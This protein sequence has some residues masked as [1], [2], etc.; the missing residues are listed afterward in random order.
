MPT[1]NV[2][3]LWHDL[4]CGGYREDLPAWRALAAATGGPV[5]DVGAGT[6]RVT[7]DLAAEGFDVVALDRDAALLA[8]LEHR[9]RGLAVET[10]HADAHEFEL[11]RR[12][13][14][15]LVPMQTLQLLDG[16]AG[17]E[18][19]LRCASAHLHPGGIVAAA[20]ADAMDCFDDEHSVPPPPEVRDVAEVRYSSQLLA[21][22]EECGRAALCRRREITD[23]TRRRDAEDVVLHLDRV[24]AE[25]VAA[26]ALPLGLVGE[27]PRYVPE[28]EQYLGST[29]VILRKPR[30]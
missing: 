28:T 10:V 9:A 1:V 7:L 13:S 19:F 20:L 12:F 26:E 15:I 30:Q 14:L 4:E 5:L 8:A 6:G 23:S 22:V 29:I 25:Q 17:R 21:V 27:D 16:R 3:A 11:A 2:A 18:A 24:S